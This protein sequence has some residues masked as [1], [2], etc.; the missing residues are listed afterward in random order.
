MSD[1]KNSVPKDEVNGNFLC[2][3]PTRSKNVERING[4][5]VVEKSYDEKSQIFIL[6]LKGQD[7]SI[8]MTK[9]LVKSLYTKKDDTYGFVGLENEMV[10]GCQ[11]VNKSF[12]ENEVKGCRVVNKSYVENGPS[13]ILNLNGQV[14]PVAIT[15]DLVKSLLAMTVPTI[16]QLQDSIESEFIKSK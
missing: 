14:E 4:Y 6:R 3:F 12:V 1:E 2:C 15:R 9:D 8:T 16:D 13:F 5:Q 11:V 7:F 10:N